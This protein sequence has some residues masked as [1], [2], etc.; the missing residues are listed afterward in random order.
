MKIIKLAPPRMNVNSYDEGKYPTVN[1][2]WKVNKKFFTSLNTS[3]QLSGIYYGLKKALVKQNF[4]AYKVREIDGEL[5]YETCNILVSAK[6][7]YLYINNEHYCGKMN[8]VYI[9]S[10]Y[11]KIRS[12]NDFKH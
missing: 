1:F 3:L 11:L 2:L 10:D 12:E 5:E 9:Y 8:D 6:V 7:C 4:E